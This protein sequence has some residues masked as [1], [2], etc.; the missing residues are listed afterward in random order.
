MSNRLR[1]LAIESGMIVGE[2]NGFDMTKLMPREVKFAQ[3]VIDE[4]IWKIMLRREEAIDNGWRVDETLSTIML[5]IEELKE[6][7]NLHHSR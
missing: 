1:E 6:N 7:A 4:C 5:D 2:A 3:L